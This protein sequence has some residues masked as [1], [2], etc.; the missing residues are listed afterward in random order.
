MNARTHV[1]F[2]VDEYL[3]LLVN[4]VDNDLAG[5]IQHAQNAEHNSV[6]DSR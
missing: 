6:I 1:R 5:R 3:C 4:N 2:H